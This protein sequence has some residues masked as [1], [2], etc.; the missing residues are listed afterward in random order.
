MKLKDCPI[1]QTVEWRNAVET[2]VLL[3]APST[4]YVAEELWERLGKPYSVHKQSWPVFDESL[5]KQET[6]EIVVQV[7]GKVR[8]RL[9]VPVGLPQDEAVSQALAS[10][11]VSEQLDGRAP[12]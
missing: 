12:D 6:A 11:R 2:L 10:P 5:A 9:T 1:A 4:P 7:N 8:E 3:M